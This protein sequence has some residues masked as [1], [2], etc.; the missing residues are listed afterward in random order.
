MGY[1]KGCDVAKV[2]TSLSGNVTTAHTQ[3]VRNTSP[4][5]PGIIC[6]LMNSANDAG[7]K[8]PVELPW[9]LDF[10]IEQDQHST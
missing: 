4:F 10:T 3:R 5:F 9:T 8:I 7:E 1:A 6:N 2:H